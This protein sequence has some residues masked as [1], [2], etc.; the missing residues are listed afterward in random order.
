[1]RQ[2][3]PETHVFWVHSGSR[4]AFEES[5]R[6]IAEKLQLAGHAI[7]NTDILRL[8][9][10]WLRDDNHGQSMMV[11]DNADNADIFVPRGASLIAPAQRRAQPSP[12]APFLPRNGNGMLLVTSRNQSTAELLAGPT[13]WE[14][15]PLD[16]DEARKLLRKQLGSRRDIV[17]DK[18]AHYLAKALA[19]NPFAVAQAATL[20]ARRTATRKQI[21]P[22]DYLQMLQQEQDRVERG[23]KSEGVRPEVGPMNDVQRQRKIARAV[24]RAW[25]IT[26]EQVRREDRSA[27]DLLLFMSFLNPQ[28]IQE[29]ILKS[30]YR[31]QE[32]EDGYR[33]S[34]PA[35][36][37]LER[38]PNGARRVGNVQD[39]Y[40]YSVE[41][42]DMRF[43]DPGRGSFSQTEVARSGGGPMYIYNDRDQSRRD[44]KRSSNTRGSSSAC[45]RPDN[46][47]NRL[48]SIDRFEYDMA[49]LRRYTLV[50]P[51]VQRD[52]Y[53][54]HPLVQ[55]CT[56]AWLTVHDIGNKW[57]SQFIDV[58]VSEYPEQ[59]D[60]HSDTSYDLCQSGMINRKFANSRS[61]WPQ[62]DEAAWTA[63]CREL[64][65]HIERTIID[66]S[67]RKPGDG[68][69]SGMDALKRA[70]LFQNVGKFRIGLGRFGEAEQ[71][72]RQAADVN[73]SLLGSKSAATL[74]CLSGLATALS[75][76]AKKRNNKMGG[77]SGGRYNNKKTADRRKRNADRVD[78]KSR[79]EEEKEQKEARRAEE[80]AECLRRRVLR[81]KEKALGEYHPDTIASRRALAESLEGL[82]DY[83]GAE[84]VHRKVVASCKRRWKP[85][86]PRTLESVENLARVLEMQNNKEEAE[87]LVRRLLSER[88]K[89]LGRDHDDTIRTIIHLAE[90]ERAKERLD[91]ARDLFEKAWFLRADLLGESHPD[92]VQVER[93]LVAVEEDMGLVTRSERGEEQGEDNGS[94]WETEAGSE[95]GSDVQKEDARSGWK[96]E[97]GTEGGS[98]METEYP[99]DYMDDQRTEE[100]HSDERYGMR[101]EHITSR[102]VS[103]GYGGNSRYGHRNERGGV[104]AYSD[105]LDSGVEFDRR[106]RTEAVDWSETGSREEVWERDYRSSYHQRPV[107]YRH[108]WPPSEQ[109][110][111]QTSE[112]LRSYE[113]SEE[114]MSKNEQYEWS[115][116]EATRGYHDNCYL[117]EVEDMDGG[118]S[119]QWQE[120]EEGDMESA[121]SSQSSQSKPWEEEEE[122]E[123]GEEENDEDDDT[124]DDG[125]TDDDDEADDESND[126]DDTDGNSDDDTDD[127][128]DDNLDDDTDDGDD[129]GDDDEDGDEDSDKNGNEDDE[130]DSDEDGGEDEDDDD[131]D[132]DGDEDDENE[133]EEDEDDKE[134]VNDDD[135]EDNDEEEDEEEEEEEEEEENKEEEEEEEEEEHEEEDDNSEEEEYDIDNNSRSY[136]PAPSDGSIGS[137]W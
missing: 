49:V 54:M 71:L 2:L 116:E 109:S 87:G 113:V 97:G 123:E 131:N 11:L 121:Q 105:Y 18:G 78:N 129:D 135:E 69:G 5:Y 99:K 39:Y 38:T 79:K 63:K 43:G 75:C 102:D 91:E 76:G 17:D 59:P 82:G 62:M 4:A 25:D 101:E 16:D 96:T 55:A 130:E 1:M 70:K 42:R 124:D 73:Q 65:P 50:T 74:S 133:E 47:S 36:S 52:V 12:L 53:E 34:G 68:T 6:G 112:R 56:Q 45:L 19:Y 24:G 134:E 28:G 15:D 84:A 128:T 85:D 122:E 33:A 22:F 23:D 13:L 26:F 67:A 8:V 57:K 3:F 14:V 137:G 41:Y 119:K 37:I 29:W 110:R 21:T 108:E 114:Y 127:D 120:E 31:R 86:D 35:T 103:E 93:L 46:G 88:R 132:D 111:H 40:S 9:S 44:G 94:E 125:D 77:G 27:A 60:S 10:S 136:S 89:V 32:E 81:A 90:L 83:Q 80:E 7:P 118:Q 100:P 20:M 64:E 48:S 72:L 117:V 107:Y 126:G 61:V 51:T 92:T 106:A 30:Y 115:E 95:G 58:M 104:E 66:P 98:D